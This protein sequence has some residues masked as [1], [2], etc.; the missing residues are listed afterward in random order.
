MGPERPTIRVA[1][2]HNGSMYLDGAKLDP[3]SLAKI[4]REASRIGPPDP[5]FVLET[6][7]GAP[8]SQL[9]EVRDI[10][11]RELKCGSG[12]HCDEGAMSLWE[13]LQV[14]GPVP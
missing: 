5:V 11:T 13:Q 3:P 4:L 12:G 8:C 9:D 14:T 7:R 2:D 1:L 6:E 10:M